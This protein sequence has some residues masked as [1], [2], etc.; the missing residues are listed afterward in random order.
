MILAGIDFETTGLLPGGR[1]I[2]VAVVLYD[3]VFSRVIEQYAA[4]ING[5]DYPVI[6]AEAEAVHGISHE[7][8]QKHGR[9]PHSVFKEVVRL[10]SQSE[11]LVAHNGH[12]FDFPLLELELRRHR[13][14]H[15]KVSYVDTQVDVAYPVKCTSRRLQHLAVDH[16]VRMRKAHS[17]LD[18]V[19]TMLDVLSFYNISEIIERAKSPLVKVIA[20]ISREK[21][22]L[23]KKRRF[24][25]DPDKRQWHK[26][27]KEYDLQEF[28]SDC[29]F[30]TVL[31]KK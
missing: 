18:D 4:L 5:H 26:S 28:L 9:H 13:I 19:L 17:A 27:V 29:P 3:T 10:I 8:T 11:Y 16:G 22:D 21:N 14:E 24:M 6:T 31:E 2:E 30:K 25:W 12:G 15:P 7:L 23:V 20:E 1:A